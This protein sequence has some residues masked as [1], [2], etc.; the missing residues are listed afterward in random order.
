MIPL[1][2]IIS[3][4]CDE[5][6]I[7]LNVAKCG[8]L[9]THP[10]PRTLTVSGEAI[11][12]VDGYTYL[13]FPVRSTGI[14]FAS[15]LRTRIESAV[16]RAAWIGLHSDSWGAADRVRVYRQYLAPMF[17]YGA[18]LV[19][20]WCR[21]RGNKRV[22]KQAIRR[23]SGLLAW[24][25]NVKTASRDNVT[26][27][28]CG[29]LPLLER[30]SHLRT[31][32]QWT[33]ER[34]GADNPLVKLLGLVSPTH[35]KPYL[36]FL[37]HLSVDEGWKRFKTAGNF[38]PSVPRALRRFLADARKEVISKT[39]QKAHITAIIPMDSRKVPGLALADISL[40]AP[41]SYSDVLFQYRRGTFMFS[42][43]CPCGETVL[44]RW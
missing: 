19:H 6:A 3:D 23:H 9:S 7:R 21:Q 40:A 16:K 43:K 31:A 29:L 14:D 22:F 36:R 26:M 12:V 37:H 34:S 38:Q 42:F 41:A 1:L 24:I 30:F 10:N 44:L 28:L 33:L 5:Y 32:Y 35:P 2:P 39:S 15:H 4:W 27:N 13:G 8:H 11:R 18:P 20:A 25:A 17:E